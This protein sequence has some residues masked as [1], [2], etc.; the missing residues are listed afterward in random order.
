LLLLV[1]F[2]RLFIQS[3]LVY[4][5]KTV[6]VGRG[7]DRMLV[8]NEKI[9]PAG[10]AIRLALEWMENNAEPHATLA[11]LPEGVMVNYLSRRVNPTRYVAWNP[12]EL[13]VFGQKNMLLDFREH[14]PDY[15]ML[16]HRDASEFGVK[17]FGQEPK[18]GLE[19]MQWIGQNYET[20]CL[21]GHEPLR[22]SL[23]GIKILK[24][25]SAG[26]GSWPAGASTFSQNEN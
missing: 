19:L 9:N 6:T 15:V 1:G 8:F 23:F 18:F 26:S 14:C 16:I 11:V 10:S 7:D 22:S 25:C 24:R 3:H 13:A 5:G 12:A 21:I 2:L 17:L 20:A 4:Q